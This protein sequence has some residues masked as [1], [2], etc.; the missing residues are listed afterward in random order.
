MPRPSSMADER[1]R[2]LAGPGVFA[3][4]QTSVE[5]YNQLNP[6]LKK[7]AL[8]NTKGYLSTMQ[9]DLNRGQVLDI[10]NIAG[11]YPAVPHGQAST[12]IGTI[13]IGAVYVQEVLNKLT[14]D[15]N[16]SIFSIFTPSR[17]A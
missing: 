14:E 9:F 17:C 1:T 10:Q 4:A 8:L 11:E 3:D 12:D 7:R 15:L 5:F 6:G 2:V 16:Q 13:M